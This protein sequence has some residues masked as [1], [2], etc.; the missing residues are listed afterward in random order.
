LF[1]F[2]I[3]IIKI[4]DALEECIENLEIRQQSISKILEIPLFYD[5][6]EIRRV[7]DEIKFAKLSIEEVAQTLG[8]IEET[9][10]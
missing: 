1:R 4:Q 5:S 6:L 7:L 8:N 10:E 2:S 9:E 3:L